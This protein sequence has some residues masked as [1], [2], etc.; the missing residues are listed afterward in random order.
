MSIA[1]DYLTKSLI[2]LNYFPN[3][4]ISSNISSSEQASTNQMTHA[5]SL[6]HRKLNY[7]YYMTS[8]DHQEQTRTYRNRQ[9]RH[10]HHRTKTQ[11]INLFG[12]FPQSQ[13]FFS[14]YS[15]SRLLILN[16]PSIKRNCILL[17]QVFNVGVPLSPFLPWNS[18]HQK[19]HIPALQ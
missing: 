13:V 3:C 10:S 7:F 12:S 6:S 17:Y 2:I 8:W 5:F 14:P 16:I 9:P 4:K 18:P 1:I 15:K 11:T 19:S